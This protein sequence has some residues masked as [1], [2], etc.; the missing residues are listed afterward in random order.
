M[1][2]VIE[3]D[4]RDSMPNESADFIQIVRRFDTARPQRTLIDVDLF[5]AATSTRRSI[6]DA[7]DFG[8]TQ[9]LDD[10][11][12]QAVDIAKDKDIP[13]VYVSDLSAGNRR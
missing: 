1:V 5:V 9:D 2:D 10:A 11:I 7:F 6:A 12:R 4:P 8:A 13:T 3:I